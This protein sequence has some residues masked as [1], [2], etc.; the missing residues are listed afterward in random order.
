MTSEG[1]KKRGRQDAQGDSEAQ[2]TD[3]VF[4]NTYISSPFLS[5]RSSPADKLLNRLEHGL[6]LFARSSMNGMKPRHI[7]QCLF[8]GIWGGVVY[9]VRAEQKRTRSRRLIGMH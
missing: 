6:L 2:G 5:F 3:G 8:C 1:L 9:R 4:S 7:Q